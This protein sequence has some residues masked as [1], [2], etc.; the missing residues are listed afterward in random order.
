MID[1]IIKLPVSFFEN[2]KEFSLDSESTQKKVK[3]TMYIIAS[4]LTEP[5]CKSREFWYRVDVIDALNPNS[6][7]VAK[8]G[9]CLLYTSPSPRDS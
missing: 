9:N 2:I 7:K 8:L 3:R 4:Y 1:S 5:L 6:S